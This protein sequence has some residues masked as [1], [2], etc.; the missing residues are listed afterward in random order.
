MHINYMLNIITYRLRCL[1]RVNNTYMCIKCLDCMP[2]SYT[3][4][5]YITVTCSGRRGVNRICR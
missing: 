5:Y 4:H 1:N 3:Q 2:Y